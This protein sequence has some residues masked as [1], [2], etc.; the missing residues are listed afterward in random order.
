M[1]VS[2][3]AMLYYGFTFLDEDE[4]DPPWKKED[5]EDYDV[6]DWLC[7]KLGGPTPPASEW[8]EELQEEF[9]NYWKAKRK[10]IEELPI[11]IGWHCYIDEPMYFICI[12]DSHHKASRGYPQ[13]L[14]GDVVSLLGWNVVM[15]EYCD[16]LGINWQKPQWELASV[17]N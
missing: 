1:T 7:E 9:S 11:M 15:R 3:D 17:W 13:K 8:S 5:D 4:N 6:E 14:G 16:R 2:T 10:F 12:R